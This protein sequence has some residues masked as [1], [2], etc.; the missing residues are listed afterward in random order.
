MQSPSCAQIYTCRNDLILANFL[1]AGHLIHQIAKFS[2]YT[3]ICPKK[4]Q[5]L[6][7]KGLQPAAESERSIWEWASSDFMI[8]LN[9]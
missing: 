6:K 5:E 4:A 9:V 3:I 7:L 2:A 8:K 1:A